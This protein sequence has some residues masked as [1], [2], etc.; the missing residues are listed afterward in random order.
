MD[1]GGQ[2]DARVATGGVNM[3]VTVVAKDLGYGG[4][5]RTVIE[6]AHGLQSAGHRVTLAVPES[7]AVDWPV[8]CP[9]VRIAPDGP[10][11]LQGSEVAVAADTESFDVAARCAGGR[12]IRFLGRFDPFYVP[13][14]AAAERSI[15]EA[16]VW[17]TS[18]SIGALVRSRF[19]KVATVLHPGVDPSVFRVRPERRP[20]GVG[21][22]VLLLVAPEGPGLPP[23]GLGVAYAALDRVRSA[24]PGVECHALCRGG[25]RPP[26]E[27]WV[28]HGRLPDHQLALLY[29]SVDLFIHPAG[30]E[31][32]PISVLEAMACG[33]PVAGVY[34]DGMNEIAVSGYN[35]VLAPPGDVERLAR[36]IQ[37]ALT[38]L[39]LRTH[40]IAGGLETAR[41]AHWTRLYQEAVKAVV[42]A[43]STW[44]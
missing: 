1:S 18:E 30:G 28:L 10:N 17:V 19:G 34:G 7:A 25:V 8:Q 42:R 4:H 36:M 11:N 23:R 38:D 40:L 33:T 29:N 43:A 32:A 6:L 41:E 5:A 39:T 2:S 35:A 16:A 20:A 14:T 15:R 22:K 26:G 13:D 31:R 12:V 44:R 24:L 9:L 21:Q 27:G 3:R 37:L